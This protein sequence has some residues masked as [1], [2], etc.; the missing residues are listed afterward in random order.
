MI[1]LGL[2]EAHRLLWVT[3]MASVELGWHGDSDFQAVV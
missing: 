1:K 2:R 3:D